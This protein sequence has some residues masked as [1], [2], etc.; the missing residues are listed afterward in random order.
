[1]IWLDVIRWLER[2]AKLDELIE[3]KN[4]EIRRVRDMACGTVGNM[5]GMPHAPGVADKVGSL[6]VKLLSLEEELKKY[7]DQRNAML[8]VLQMLP[9][10]E[11]GVLH[12]EYVRYMTR[13]EIGADMKY[14][15]VQVWRIKKKALR[16]LEIILKD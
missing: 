7:D 4:A 16:M 9:A 6:T 13:E 15:T 8:D 1:M 2:F 3:G 14:S 10:L 5:D 11:Y 12:R